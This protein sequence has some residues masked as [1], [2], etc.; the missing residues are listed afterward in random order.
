MQTYVCVS[1]GKKCQFFGKS[2]YVPNEVSPVEQ[3]KTMV[4]KFLIHLTFQ[5]RKLTQ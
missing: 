2:A 3:K 5:K 4:S 1:K